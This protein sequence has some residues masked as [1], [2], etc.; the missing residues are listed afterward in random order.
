[1]VKIHSA[2]SIIPHLSHPLLIH[3]GVPQGSV[4]GP[5]L[6]LLY[7]NDLPTHLSIGTLSI[8]ADDTSHLLTSPK[9]NILPLIHSANNQV[10]EMSSFCLNNS[11][12]LNLTKTVFLNFHSQF[13]PPN[14]SPLIRLNNKSISSTPAT[15]FLG[16]SLTD[17]L[18]WSPHI[19]LTSSRILTGCFMLRKLKLLVNPHALLT[20]YHAHIHSLI[21]YGLIFWGSSPASNRIFILQKRAVRIIA[22]LS[23][24]QSC[25][26][27]FLSLG[28]LTLPSTLIQAAA[29]YVR[30]H[31]ETFQLN[32]SVHYH[33]TRT[34]HNIFIPPHNFTLSTKSPK[35]LCSTLYNNL[36]LSIKSSPSITSFK[37]SLKTFL[38]TKA[39]Y[40]L[41]EYLS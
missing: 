15:K 27:H 25:K 14:Y 36:P 8:Y 1:M 7:I 28:I 31:P 4:L 41:N 38:K 2:T 29:L 13:N 12:A 33:S 40:S 19:H 18:D 9:S 20:V 24:R 32:S 35:R 16:L 10:S 34:N 6:F 5:L 23:R 11:L 17:T 21:S 3:N 39:F 22:G 26:P 37:S 30:L